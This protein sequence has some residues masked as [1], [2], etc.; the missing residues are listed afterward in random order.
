MDKSGDVIRPN[1]LMG[2][3]SVDKITRKTHLDNGFQQ[4]MISSTLRKT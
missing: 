2:P 1:P 4:L 3:N